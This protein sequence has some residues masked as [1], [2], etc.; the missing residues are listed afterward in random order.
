MLKRA[1]L[2][3]I[4]FHYAIIAESLVASF[5]EKMGWCAGAPQKI[6]RIEKVTLSVAKIEGA[7]VLATP[8]INQRSRSRYA[9]RRY[10][11]SNTN[12]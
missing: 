2:Q 3:A 11:K 6:E 5:H 8:G 9:L 4:Y 7:V 12:R 1:V 10:E